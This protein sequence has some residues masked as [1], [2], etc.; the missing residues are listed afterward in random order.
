M[1]T[2]EASSNME[3]RQ[4]VYRYVSKYVEVF[5]CLFMHNYYSSKICNELLIQPTS[6]TKNLIKDLQMVF[7]PMVGGFA[8]AANSA[9]DYSN[10]VFKS[11][12]DLNFEFKFSNPH[13]FSFTTLNPDP[14]V[15][16]FLK[17]DLK[18]SI[19]FNSDFRSDSP[20]LER[21]GISGIIN[22][23]H[24]EEAPILPIMGLESGSFEPRNKVVY[25]KPRAIKPIYICYTND[26]TLDNFEGLAI[27]IEG[28]FKGIVSFGPV[29]EIE[30]RGGMKAYK[31]T[32]EDDFIMKDSWKG[33]FRLVR[34][35]QLGSYRKILP[36]PKPQSIRFDSSTNSYISEN[37]VKL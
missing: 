36:N 20:S 6:A 21:P 3:Q 35:N 2:G 17:D 24:S 18:P 12:F 22:L 32:A 1:N 9:K 31:F 4:S 19:F 14:E 28:E 34:N 13:F 8:L 26:V 30:T 11:S 33:H 15:R 7:K 29:E 23:T 27:E 37:Y 25:M 16:Y 5:T 10:G